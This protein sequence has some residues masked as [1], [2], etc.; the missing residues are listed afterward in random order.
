[1]ESWYVLINASAGSGSGAKYWQRISRLLKEANVNHDMRISETAEE[2][3]GLI[4]KALDNGYRR[5]AVA[6]GDGTINHLVNALHRQDLIPTTELRIALLPLGTG[7]D[8]LKTH[9]IGTNLKK[10]IASL[11]SRD[12]YQH[13]VGYIDCHS[14]TG[15]QR[16]YFI[17]I[18]GF[19]FDALVVKRHKLMLSGF[20][21]G[22]LSYVYVVLTSLFDFEALP[23]EIVTDQ[24]RLRENLFNLS[25]ANCRFSG[26]GMQ[27]GPKAV[28]N[29]GLLDLTLI[30]KI[31]PFKIIANLYRLFSGTYVKQKEIS[32]HRGKEI[33]IRTN[34]FFP[35]EVDGELVPEA[36]HYTLGILPQSIAVVSAL[37]A[38]PRS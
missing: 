19:G 13:D 8:W 6:G 34:G 20:N 30:R 38:T 32:L 1:M 2:V 17:N 27:F 22:A 3:P 31:S 15:T 12:F 25:V 21:L 23:V 37:A 14:L 18:A 16:T 33:E 28:P 29:D 5:F 9:K 35:A 10:A 4:R 7:N 24:E 36:H 11:K 26:G